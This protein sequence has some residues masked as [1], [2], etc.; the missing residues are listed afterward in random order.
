MSLKHVSNSAFILVVQ[1][2]FD[3]SVPAHATVV[4]TEKDAGK[5]R[6]MDQLPNEVWYL[7][8]E[9]LLNDEDERRI[10]NVFE[11]HGISIETVS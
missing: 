2:Y 6:M 9:V 10:A 1:Q 7:E 3:L 11:R 5:V 8:I 4:V